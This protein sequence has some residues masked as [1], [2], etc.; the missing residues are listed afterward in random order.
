MSKLLILMLALF[1]LNA[2]A[3]TITLDINGVEHS[4]TPTTDSSGNAASC[5][6][7]A[8]SGPFSRDEC[9]ELCAGA[10]NNGPAEC[11]LLAYKGIYTKSESLSLC[12]RARSAGPAE[13]AKLA[14]SGPF[15]RAETLTLCSNPRATTSIAECALEAY[16]GVYSREES[17]ELCKLGG[18]HKGDKTLA[19]F[20]SMPK[21]KTDLENLIKKA[22]IKAV[23]N[24]DYK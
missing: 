6:Q 20:F 5:A 14:Y 16:A 4:C 21:S 3:S 12:Q 7:L 2:G 17:I 23:L 9:T 10:R 22:N 18:R 15:S 1:S 13:C 8:Y 24:N 11:A 19:A